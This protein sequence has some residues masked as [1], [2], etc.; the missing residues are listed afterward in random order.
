[1]FRYCNLDISITKKIDKVWL[2]ID[3]FH[4]DFFPSGMQS[5]HCKLADE[6]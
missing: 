2:P 3:L 4:N 5:E 6:L 1:M